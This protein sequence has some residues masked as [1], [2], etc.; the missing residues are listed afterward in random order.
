MNSNVIITDNYLWTNEHN[1]VSKQVLHRYQVSNNPD[2]A[3]RDG[4]AGIQAM[5]GDAKSRSERLRSYGGKWSLSDVAI[6]NDSIHDSKP[7]T[8]YGTVGADSIIGEPLYRDDPKPLAQRLYYFQSGSQINQI[9]NVLEAA[10]LSLATTGASN[11]QTIAGAVSTGTHGSA[12][13]IGAMQDYVRVLHIVTSDT[14]HVMIQPQSNPVISSKF[15]DL[16]GAQLISDDRLFNSALVSFGSFGVIHGIIVETVSLFMLESYCLRVDYANAENL[17]P[18]LTNFD[19]ASRNNLGQFLTQNNLP[20]DADPYHLSL[21][22]NPY[23]Q[24]QNAFLTVMYK[25]DYDAAKLSSEPGASDT[26]VGDDV[27]SFISSVSSA[28]EDLAPAFVNLLFGKAATVRRTPYIQTPRN[29]FGDTTMYK[30][31]GGASSSELGVGI[32]NAAQAVR[33]IMRTAQQYNFMGLIGI[34]FVRNSAATLAF[35]RFSPLTCTIELPG[36]HSEN[37]YKQVFQAMDDANIQFT[38]HWGQEGDYSPKRLAAMYGNAVKSWVEDRNRLLPDP[39][40]LYMFSNDFMKWCGLNEA[41]A[42]TGG[43]VIV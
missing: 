36:L 28:A 21:I 24:N 32:S 37:Y 11:G 35:T 9:N 2:T 26:R 8:F 15:S 40:M 30:S 34:R 29:T 41:P 38:L 31:Q 19:H 12:M 39:I 1:N 25:K 7:L 16:F 27:I 43:D 14:G 20:S 4:L 22:V 42:L 17:Y 18:L 6:C 13:S 33:I 10:G 5:I 23:S 3:W